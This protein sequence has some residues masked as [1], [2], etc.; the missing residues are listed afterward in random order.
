MAPALGA[1]LLWA[2]QPASAQVAPGDVLVTSLTT[3][4]VYR[5]DPSAPAPMAPVPV[6]TGGAFVLPVGLAVDR[7]GLLLVNDNFSSINNAIPTTLSRVDPSQNPGQGVRALVASFSLLTASL[8]GVVEARDGRVFIADPGRVIPQLAPRRGF[9]Y[10]PVISAVD[11]VD[12][13]SFGQAVAG[14]P[15]PLTCGNLYFPSAVAVESEAPELTLLV[16]DAGELDGSGPARIHQGVIR[17]FADRPMD[18]LDDPTVYPVVGTNDELFCAPGPFAT[19]R[20]LSIDRSPGREGSVLVTDSGNSALGIP[21]RVFRIAASGCDPLEDPP[22]EIVAEGSGLVRPIGIA[23]ADDGIIFVADALA[24]TVFWIDPDTHAVSPLSNV[25]SIDQAWDLQIQRTRPGPYFVADAAVPTV[26]AVDPAVPSRATV[27]SGGSFAAPAALEVL[28]A[29]AGV[30][31]ADPTAR[32]VIETALSGVQTVAS[33][34]GRLS[35]PTSASR[36][37]TGTYLVTDLGDAGAMPP[38]LPAVIRVDPSLASPGNQTLVSEGGKLVQPVAGAIDG[39]GYLIVADAG[40]GSEANPPRILRISPE[41]GQGAAG[42]VVLSPEPADPP[43]A[44]LPLY[45][46]AALA[47]DEGGNVVLVAD[48]GDETH[49]PAVLRLTRTPEPPGATPVALAVALSSG[50]LLETPAGL[51]IDTDGSIL[52]SDEGDAASADDGKVIRVDAL[53]GLQSPVPSAGTLA[54]PTG[55]GVQPP[56]AG[57]FPDQDDDHIADR[58]DNCISVAN[59]DQ[60]DTDDPP[61]AIGNACDPDYNTDGEVGSLDFSALRAALGSDVNDPEPNRYDP[62]IDADGDGTIGMLEFDLLQGCYGGRPGMSGRLPFIPA[63]DY[64][65]PP[66]VAP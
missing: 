49:A 45:S 51:A 15:G 21:P 26:L 60:R 17:V 39:E 44:L 28:P 33:Q 58:E 7:N 47:L 42:Q 52:V 34:A 30:V 1:A 54:L 19:P 43:V 31:V 57:A 10:F 25:G 2:S 41:A 27:S 12:G 66:L 16:A 35:S 40:D 20:S 18:F 32:A 36:E 6:P 46:P 56:A 62:D 5:L 23:V 50:G 65:R 29:A 61:D 3:G 48:R 59:T 55:I 9:T 24:D 37:V 53:S 4:E 22:V 64:C 14:C 11:V 38:L 13:I 8:R 63:A